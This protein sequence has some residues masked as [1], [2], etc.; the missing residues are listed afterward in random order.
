MG[1]LNGTNFKSA[2]SPSILWLSPHRQCHSFFLSFHFNSSSSSD[3]ALIRKLQ[4]SFGS[5]P[6]TEISIWIR[7]LNLGCLAVRLN[8]PRR[9]IL[10][11]PIPVWILI[12]PLSHHTRWSSWPCMCM[13][14]GKANTYR[15]PARVQSVSC[16]ESGRRGG[17]EAAK[18]TYWA[19]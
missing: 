11:T 15:R 14:H 16:Y 8:R 3:S 9:G 13:C 18:N 5:I 1:C 7:Y 17:L 6:S 12:R 4:A 10:S 2:I 19:R